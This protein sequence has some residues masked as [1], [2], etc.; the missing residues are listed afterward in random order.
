MQGKQATAAN[1]RKAIHDV[2]EYAKE[3]NNLVSSLEGFKPFGDLRGFKGR[4]E[5]MDKN[6]T[7][8]I[9]KGLGFAA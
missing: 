4:R 9:L 5:N 1:L 8:W 3:F 6:S 2:F 7:R